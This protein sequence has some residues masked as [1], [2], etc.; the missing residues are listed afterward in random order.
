MISGKAETL[1]SLTKLVKNSRIPKSFAF[2][3]LDWRCKSSFLLDKIQ[4]DFGGELLA[5]RSS[6]AAEDGPEQSLA[7]HYSSVLNVASGVRSEL[8]DAVERVVNSLVDAGIG[9]DEDNQVL[10]QAMITNVTASGVLFTRDMNSGAPYFVINYDDTSLTT[11]VVTS[12]KGELSNKTLLVLRDRVGSVTSVR[13]SSLLTAVL[14]LEELLGSDCLD[15]EFAITESL[16]VFIL[17]VRRIVAVDARLPFNDLEFRLYLEKVRKSTMELLSRSFESQSLNKMYGQMPDWNPVEIIGRL[18]SPLSYSVYRELITDSVWGE[19]RALMGYKDMSKYQLMVQV[20]GSPYID[21]GLSLYSFIPDGVPKSIADLMVETSLLLLKENPQKHDKLEFDVA[22][23]TFCFSIESRLEE[24]YGSGLSVSDKRL[25]KNC[26]IE[27]FKRNLDSS[28]PGSIQAAK[29]SLRELDKV[30]TSDPKRYPI[31]RLEKLITICKTFGTIPFAILARHAFIA[32]AILN[33]LKDS[34]VLSDERYNLFFLGLHTVARNLVDDLHLVSEHALSSDSFMEVYGHLRPDTYN[35]CSPRYDQMKDGIFDI[36]DLPNYERSSFEFSNVEVEHMKKL[37]LKNG[38]GELDASYVFD[39]LKQSIVMR[40]LAKFKFTRLLSYILEV[41][42]FNADELGYSR[43]DISS[44]TL[45]SIVEAMKINSKDNLI[46][47]INASIS[48][49]KES[50]VLARALKLPSLLY[51][52]SQIDVIPFQTATPN[53]ITNKS[54]SAS[55]SVI[56]GHSGIAGK[57]SYAEK[58]VITENADPGYDWLFSK[59]ISGLITK[60]GGVN[61]HMSIRC[62]EFGLPAAIGCGEDLFEFCINSRRLILDCGS[63]KISRT[64]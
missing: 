24:V 42:A 43:M 15:I 51:R 31:E 55:V 13:F 53:F 29:A 44:V 23:T 16:D 63:K 50:D 21:V 39:Y 30:D 56:H 46:E 6:G 40:E 35:I 54:I 18:P 10:V 19:A 38:L 36:I 41:I 17:Q 33:S 59:G 28:S 22:V 34:Q 60:Y 9:G 14:E 27:L 37:L 7:G 11:D 5:V 32:Q 62:A 20:G 12:G 45:N 48:A 47:K 2:S 61:S 58:I 8:V 26:F 4:R 3:V 1:L 64:V 57:E 49:R 25:L 52:E